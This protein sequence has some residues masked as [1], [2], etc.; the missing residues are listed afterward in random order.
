MVLKISII[1]NEDQ[2]INVDKKIEEI[3][4]VYNIDISKEVIEAR[5]KRAIPGFEEI[6]ISFLIAMGTEI[7]FKATGN[8]VNYLKKK[9]INIS[10][11]KNNREEWARNYLSYELEISNFDLE[12][13]IEK[14]AY[15]KFIFLTDTGT[16]HIIKIHKNMDI[17]YHR[18]NKE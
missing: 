17:E 11:D 7:A 9:S 5:G 14:E 1:A 6:I 13:K 8:L 18:K 16:K 3:I 2:K 4:S 10:I 12:R 15:S